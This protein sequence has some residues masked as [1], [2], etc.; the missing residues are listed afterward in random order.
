MVVGQLGTLLAHQVLSAIGSDFLDAM[1]QGPITL[2]IARDLLAG[3][4]GLRVGFKVVTEA[5]VMMGL[6]MD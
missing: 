5:C 1:A 3:P 6:P 2:E 4:R